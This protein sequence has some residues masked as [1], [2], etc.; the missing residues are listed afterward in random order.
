MKLKRWVPLIFLVLLYLLFE[1]LSY[2]GLRVAEK[3]FYLFY[4]PVI[5]TLSDMQKKRL[6]SFTE[7]GKGQ[8]VGQHPVLGWVSTKETN[9]SGMRDNREYRRIPPQGIVRISAFGDSFT[10]GSDAE[11][12]DTWIKRL[13][14]FDSSLEIL[15]YGVG[16]YGLDQA[17]LRYLEIGTEYNPHIVFLGYMSENIVRNVN[18]FRG[19]YTNSYRNTIFTKPRFRLKNGKLNLIDNPISTLEDHK[20]FLNNDQEVL[21]KLG[22][23]DYHY[24]INYSS[25]LLD[26][27]PSVRLVKIFWFNLNTRV[28]DPIFKLGGMYSDTSEAYQVTVE[29]FDNFYRNVLE[30]GAL[31]IVL[32]FPD[33][34]DQRR[35]REKKKRR[36]S[37]LLSYFRSEGYYYI[38]TLGAL[39]P[40][41]R[42]YRIKDLA[43]KWGHYSPI[44]HKIIAKYIYTHLSSLGF[45]NLPQIKEAIKKERERLGLVKSYS[46]ILNRR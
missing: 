25:S 14:E 41:E 32:I 42:S 23:N 19:F 29:I 13:N 27:L 44:G 40:Y 12:P 16:A 17:Y 33:S 37:P 20:Y 39:E 3:N 1:G 9:S 34:N 21:V 2:V 30:N 46:P 45:T 11:L 26:F 18:V 35:S 4:D 5:E 6:R 36:Y 15:N 38:D 43:V 8:N 22:Q 31:P 24:Q 7:S 28:F 10:Y